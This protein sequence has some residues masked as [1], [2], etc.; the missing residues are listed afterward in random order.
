MINTGYLAI[1]SKYEKLI[2]SGTIERSASQPG[3]YDYNV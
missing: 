1:P 2:T 3:P